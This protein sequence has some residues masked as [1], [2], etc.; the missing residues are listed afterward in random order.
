M[1]KILHIPSGNFLYFKITKHLMFTEHEFESRMLT[2]TLDSRYLNPKNQLINRKLPRSYTYYR[3]LQ[4]KCRLTL[5][6]YLWILLKNSKNSNFF[7]K[8]SYK[9]FEI[10]ED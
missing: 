7:N 4:T 8:Y 2:L 5:K 3:M 9:Q 10:V 1:Y 6:F